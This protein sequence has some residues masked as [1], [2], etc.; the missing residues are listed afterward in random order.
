M[1]ARESVIDTGRW[2]NETFKFDHPDRIAVGP[3][4][5]VNPFKFQRWCEVFARC[6]RANRAPYLSY[7]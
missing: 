1:I 6:V 2:G 5:P 4:N 3:C 7:Q